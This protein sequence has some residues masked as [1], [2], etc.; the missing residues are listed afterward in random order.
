MKMLGLVHLNW[1]L[2]CQ[3]A[4][5]VVSWATL[6]LWIPNCM[7]S[8]R[9]KLRSSL[10]VNCFCLVLQGA[11]LDPF[12]SFDPHLSCSPNKLSPAPQRCHRPAKARKERWQFHIFHMTYIQWSKWSKI[13]KFHRFHKTCLAFNATHHTKK[14]QNY[15]L[16]FW[17]CVV[18]CQSSKQFTSMHMVFFKQTCFCREWFVC[19][20]SSMFI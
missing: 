12:A 13:H 2:K 3:N 8:W 20:N 14:T 9:T 16:S 10:L 4:I 15:G 17:S 5:V 11:R 6:T 1:T 18:F 19:T 7:K